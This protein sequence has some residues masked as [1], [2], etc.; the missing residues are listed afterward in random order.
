MKNA[1]IEPWELTIPNDR[2]GPRGG[3]A[4]QSAPLWLLKNPFAILSLW[5]E[6]TAYLVYCFNKLY[7]KNIIYLLP[8]KIELQ[9][10]LFVNTCRSCEKIASIENEM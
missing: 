8:Q 3:Q 9:N 7:Y 2:D 5:N 10:L 1:L 4:G 6:L